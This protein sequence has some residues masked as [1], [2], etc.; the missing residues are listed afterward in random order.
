VKRWKRK[1]NR[2]DGINR[3]DFLK[4]TAVLG[5]T[6]LAS[7]LEWATDLMRRAEAGQLTPE[8]EYELV[9]AENTLY[10]VCLQ[11]NTG[12]GIK[13][14]FFRKN[15]S[16]VALKI[17]GSPY[18][19]F[20]SVPH[21]PYGTSPSE[22]NKVDMAIC[23]K[24]QAGLQSVYDPYRITK[25]IKRAGKRGEGKWM[26]VPFDRAVDEIVG[27]GKLFRHVPGE[28]NREV[29]GLK[30]IHALRDPKIA[31]EMGEDAKAIGKAKDKE[32]GRRGIQGKAC[33]EPFAPH[34]PGPPGSGAQE[35]PDGL[36]VGPEE[37]R[38]GGLLRAVLR[39][40]LRRSTPTAT[41]RCARGRSTSP[42]R[43]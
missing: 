17:D 6:V 12:C 42:A 18:N 5:G 2:W 37:G 29:T 8:E 19:P 15:G 16:A 13:V 11:C 30:E 34:R 21:A 3:R 36:H 20:V 27:G 7:Q 40:L 28:E 4:C 10:T 9:R 32:E 25:V 22:L 38:P 24:G 35:Q 33:A 26:T 14:K 41:R 43:R 1:R 23:P 39:G 31:K